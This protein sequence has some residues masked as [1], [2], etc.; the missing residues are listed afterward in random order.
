M[1]ENFCV[2]RYQLNVQIWKGDCGVMINAKLLKQFQAGARFSFCLQCG[3]K[4]VK[5][6]NAD[7]DELIKHGASTKPIPPANKKAKQGSPNG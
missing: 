2:W 3:K 4:M 6:T 7:V 1:S 5:E